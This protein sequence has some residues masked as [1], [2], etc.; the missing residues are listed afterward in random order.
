[1]RGPPKE[2]KHLGMLSSFR[3]TH[4]PTGALAC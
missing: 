2:H 3:V 4:K 1:M